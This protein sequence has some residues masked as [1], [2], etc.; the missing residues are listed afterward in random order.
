VSSW[1]RASRSA[2]KCAD[3]SGHAPSVCRL[4]RL[5]LA[6]G[7][8][9]TGVLIRLGTLAFYFVAAKTNDLMDELLKLES[10]VRDIYERTLHPIAETVGFA[11]PK[12]SKHAAGSPTVLFVGNHAAGK[13][14]FINYLLGVELQRSGV[15]PT[16]DGFTIIQFGER[17]SEFDGQTIAGR[18]DIGFPDLQRFG[19]IFLGRLRLKTYPHDLLRTVTLVDTPG[20][21]DSSEKGHTR[22]YDFAGAVS[23]FA[24]QSDLIVCFFDPAKPRLT[25]E[26]VSL[27]SATLARMDYNV[28]LTLN[29]V[30]L[31]STIPEFAR[32]YG[33]LCCDVSKTLT[34]RDAPEI[35]SIYVPGRDYS[36]RPNCAIPLRDFDLARENLIQEIQRTPTRRWIIS[37]VIFISAHCN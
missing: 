19:P 28:L 8:H 2:L 15:A 4:L 25:S 34:T 21:I 30:D 6:H 7:H 5:D 37:S 10:R 26:T 11:F 33:A 13:S 31:F 20:M 16:E 1:P 29:K 22:D 9:G 23:S 12:H 3:D 32:T 24:E 14:T 17:I 36:P 18:Q 35:F 27:F